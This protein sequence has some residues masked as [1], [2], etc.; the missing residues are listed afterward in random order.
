MDPQLKH[1]FQA[2]K[3][4]KRNWWPGW[5]KN[6]KTWNIELGAIF[7]TLIAKVLLCC[8]VIQQYR[9]FPDS[10][11]RDFQLCEVNGWICAGTQI[12]PFFII[13]L[14]GHFFKK[15]KSLL[16]LS[17]YCHILFC[18]LTWCDLGFSVRGVHT[19]DDSR[20]T[21]KNCS[22]LSFVTFYCFH[23]RK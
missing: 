20:A 14:M 4:N 7:M 6:S 11:L 21:L 23:Q 2:V 16:S 18:Q 12:K 19:L 5:G 10:Y 17:Q 9:T 3:N 8:S 1:L 22:F 15:N 13:F